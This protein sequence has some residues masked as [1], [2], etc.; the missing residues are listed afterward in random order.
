MKTFNS[1][2]AFVS[3]LFLLA[4]CFCGCSSGDWK[5]TLF[6][7][8][9]PEYNC[10]PESPSDGGYIKLRVNYSGEGEPEI[11]GDSICFKIYEWDGPTGSSV[12]DNTATGA[13][14]YRADDFMTK[15][16]VAVSDIGSLINPPSA[17]W[18]ILIEVICENC[19]ERNDRCDLKIRIRYPGRTDGKWSNPIP[20]PTNESDD[21]TE[22]QLF[23]YVEFL[24]GN[25]IIDMKFTKAYNLKCNC[26]R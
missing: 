18:D 5:F 2:P 9:L 11:E 1:F 14:W 10:H 4:V 8:P 19:D 21:F 13:P 24:N 3:S 23:A 6:P 26:K 25:E 22:Y 12:G 20:H 16:C 7:D 15:I 17:L